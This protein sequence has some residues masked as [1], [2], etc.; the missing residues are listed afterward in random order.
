MHYLKNSLLL[1]L[2]ATLIGCGKSA[3]PEQPK[4]TDE[5]IKEQMK[6]GAERR[7]YSSPRPQV[8]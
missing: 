1:L 6:K 8:P 2:A 5:Q 3:E 4:L 7:E